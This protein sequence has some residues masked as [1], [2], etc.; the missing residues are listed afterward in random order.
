MYITPFQGL[1]ILMFS[2]PGRCPRRYTQVSHAY[3]SPPIQA[4]AKQ[5]SKKNISENSSTYFHAFGAA[6]SAIHS[7]SKTIRAKQSFG[8]P[9][10][11]L[12]K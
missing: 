7:H 3:K 11:L 6:S 2:N 8:M 9:C 10:F 1:K 4:Q 12:H 5:K